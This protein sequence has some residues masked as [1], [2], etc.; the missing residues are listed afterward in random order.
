MAQNTSMRHAESRIRLEF[1]YLRLFSH[2]YVL[3][4]GKD[5]YGFD[6][7][8]FRFS[9]LIS[10]EIRLMLLSC[11]CPVRSVRGVLLIYTSAD[12]Y[13]LLFLLC[14]WCGA[15]YCGVVTLG[16]PPPC[17]SPVALSP[18]LPGALCG[19]L[20]L[21]PR[22]SFDTRVRRTTTPQGVPGSPCSHP[23]GPAEPICRQGLGGG[24]RTHQFGHAPEINIPLGHLLLESR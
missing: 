24:V 13:F 10:I 9:N 6:P 5:R 18:V 23:V 22:V 3:R 12:L 14:F 1:C 7:T 8:T 21:L 19:Y 20:R 11:G 2:I 17:P 16:I 15:G 4:W